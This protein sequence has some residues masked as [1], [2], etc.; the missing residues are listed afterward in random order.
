[1]LVG[2]AV[3]QKDAPVAALDDRRACSCW[4]M[5]KRRSWSVSVSR[6]TPMFGSPSRSTKIERPPM[7]SI[8]FTTAAP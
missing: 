5:A 4:I 8:G 3:D 7:P 6:I 1:V 2:L